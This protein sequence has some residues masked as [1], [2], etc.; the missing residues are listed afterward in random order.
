M[1]IIMATNLNIDIDLLQEAYKIGHFKT[2]REA[3]NAALKEFIQR[4]KQKD[5][6]KYL[7]KIDFDN[8]YNYKASR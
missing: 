5:I 6:L 8:S 3:V 7:N 2:K 4:K 1:E